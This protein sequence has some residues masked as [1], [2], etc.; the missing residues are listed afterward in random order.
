MQAGSAPRPRL[1]QGRV[2]CR[3]SL[4]AAGNR[5]DGGRLQACEAPPSLELPCWGA[6]EKGDPRWPG[7]CSLDG[8]EPTGCP[9]LGGLEVRASGGGRGLD[10][11]GSHGQGH[12][13][14]FKSL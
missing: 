1:L 13:G 6:R 9:S 10:G 12:P 7:G 11:S 5:E 4:R 8:A 2:Y 14:H 3:D